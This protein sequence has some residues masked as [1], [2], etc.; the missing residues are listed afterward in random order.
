[1]DKLVQYS[2]Q[3]SSIIHSDRQPLDPILWKEKTLQDEYKIW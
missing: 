1:M 2:K 3:V